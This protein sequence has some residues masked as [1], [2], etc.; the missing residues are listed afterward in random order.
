MKK[1][2]LIL[3]GI[4]LACVAILTF[5]FHSKEQDKEQDANRQRTEPARKARLE[6]LEQEKIELEQIE[7]EEL[8]KIKA[9]E[10]KQKDN[11]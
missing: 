8:L 4:A 11:S 7:K 10:A 3:G 5:L 1:L 9:N 6:K 2:V